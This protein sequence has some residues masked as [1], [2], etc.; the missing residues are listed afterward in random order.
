MR[1]ALLGL[2]LL[3]VGSGAQASGWDRVALPSDDAG[4]AG[5]TAAPRGAGAWWE[6]LGDD[7]LV[8]LVE[9]ALTQNSDASAAWQRVVQADALSAQVRA[10]LLPAVSLDGAATVAPTDALG[11][12]FGLGGAASATTDSDTYTSGSVGLNASLGVDLWTRTYRS[13]RATRHDVAAARGDRD[14]ALLALATRVVG[15]AFDVRAARARVAVVEESV[16]TSR[17]LLALTELRYQGGDATG[18]SVL[19]QR[20]QL[21]ATEA[22][23]PSARLADRLAGQ[24]LAVLLGRDPSDPLPELSASLPDLPPAPGLGAP[25]ELLGARP[26]LRAASERLEAARLR[27]QSATLGLLPTLGVSASYGEQFFGTD[28]LS[29][30]DTWSV[31]A[32]ASLPVFNGGAKWAAIREATAAERAAG[33]T[34]DAAVRGAWA[35]VEGAIARE[36]AVVATLVALRVQQ[37][38]ATAALGEARARYEGGLATYVELLTALGSAQSA[39]LSVINAQR[40]ALDARVGLLDALGGVWSSGLPEPERG[41]ASATGSER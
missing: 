35:E 6:D 14:A 32:S 13:W 18:L 12:G 28:E 4:F 22:Q 23:L 21:A 7:A 33:D 31:G 5:A 19:Q 36:D 1:R 39:D 11:F 10:G 8:A 27:R 37:E 41:R 2:A 26:D 24:Q 25:S 34:L 17:D 20:A 16:A 29:W 38:A 9:E 15:A 30:Q 40:D 3:G